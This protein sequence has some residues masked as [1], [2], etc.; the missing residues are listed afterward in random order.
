MIKFPK[1]VVGKRSD[2]DAARATRRLRYLVMRAAI[3]HTDGCTITAF[4][5]FVG[6]DRGVVHWSMRTGSFSV[7][8]A[9]QIQEK[10]GEAL[11]PKSWLIFP[12]E[13]V[14]E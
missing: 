3:E 10:C 5:D 11:M 8:A 6:L 1:W 2:T 7:P 12:L 14:S 9:V 4:A 13:I